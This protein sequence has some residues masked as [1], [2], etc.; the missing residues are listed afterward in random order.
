MLDEVKAIFN[1]TG[2]GELIALL[3]DI[4]IVYYIIYRVLLL[5]KGTKAV[6]MLIGL[7]I[8]I[9]AFVASKADFLNLP[10]L[11]WMLDTFLSSF[12]LFIIVIFQ[13]DIRRVLSQVGQSRLF[14]SF[15]TRSA[16]TQN[17]EEIV[18]A[19]AQLSEQKTGALIVLQRDADL[20]GYTESGVGLDA[21][22][23]RELL[24]SIFLAEKSN[25]LHD[26]AVV[27]YN[28]R[29][30]AAGCVLPLTNSPRVERGLGTRHRAAIGLSEE[31]DAAIVVVSE[32]T[33]AVSVAFRG[34]LTR[35]LDATR[36]R[37]ELQK[38][39]AQQGD[40]EAEPQEAPRKRSLLSWLRPGA[41]QNLK[42]EVQP[43]EGTKS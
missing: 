36:L 35:G 23:S 32:E 18:K 41:S 8:I 1:V 14:S 5:I 33:G 3:V 21:R 29:I 19:S 2:W 31:T 7:M 28:D 38:I 30:M 39:F 40:H 15:S 6:Q 9:V 42:E 10:T 22:L 17:L 34:E 20:R 43:Q 25:P 24:V 26:G 13:D 27:V 4:V 37:A 16:E 12:L 11:N